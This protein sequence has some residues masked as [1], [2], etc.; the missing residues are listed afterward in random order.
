MVYRG[1]ELGWEVTGIRRGWEKL[2]HVDLN[3]SA[4]KARY[5]LPLH[6]ENTRTIDR[7]GGTI[8]H[9]SRTSPI[10]MKKLPPVLQGQ[11]TRRERIDEEGSD[12]HRIRCDSFGA[13]EYRKAR[14]RLPHCYRRRRH[15]ELRLG[16]RPE[17]RQGDRRA[18]DDGQ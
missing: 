11:K 17:G 15:P 6:R 16:T 13:K 5:I 4:S 10:K 3:N 12:Q 7:T 14:T 18:K 9:S 1:A 8:L 2:T